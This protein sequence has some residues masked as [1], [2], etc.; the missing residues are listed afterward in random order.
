MSYQ[1]KSPPKINRREFLKLIPPFTI[2]SLVT[3][4]KMLSRASS[5][6]GNELPNII[7][8]IFDALSAKNMSLYGYPRNTTPNI[9]I[10][11][12]KAYV[13]HKH[14]A[15][16][17]FTTPGTSSL[18]SGT[19]PWTHHAI[20]IGGRMNP[21][22]LPYTI[23]NL[24]P[25]NYNKVAFT[26][27]NIANVL[28]TQLSPYI[29]KLYPS[30]TA[31][32]NSTIW[33]SDLF[34]SDYD[35]AT[36]AEGI[37]RANDYPIP[38]LLL[39]SIFE[40]FT[41]RIRIKKINQMHSTMFPMGVPYVIQGAHFLLEDVTRWMLETIV[42]TH[43]PFIAYF[44]LNPPHHPYLPRAEFIGKFNDNL[45][46]PDKPQHFFNLGI[47]NET[48][49]NERR[50]YDEFIAYTDVEFGKFYQQLEATGLLENTIFILT[51]DHGELFERGIIRHTTE[52]LY[53]PLIHIPLVIKLP[54]QKKRV[55]VHSSTSCTD[56]L[57][58]L[59][60]LT[61]T[62]HSSSIPEGQIL[63]GI[64]PHSLNTEPRPV[65]AIEAKRNS[66]FLP[67]QKGTIAM[68]KGDYKIIQYLGY[69]ELTNPVE[70]YNLG[71]D[72]EEL[73]NIYHSAPIVAKNLLGELNET[74]HAKNQ[75]YLKPNN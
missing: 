16:G 17:N 72:P 33:A 58:T 12:E 73:N 51:S 35:L 68:I 69:Q 21:A 56:I 61:R 18:L 30:E 31:A 39:E 55:D 60:Y 63:P 53:E 49:L 20:N 36:R 44:H 62:E 29:N 25:K 40:N 23:F 22:I 27:N 26:Q 50:L 11:A 10:F 4:K 46:F 41:D 54:G 65:F 66:S 6:E 28:L 9:E 24:L 74:L 3:G 42:N 52:V 32:L 67:I 71:E 7:I 57:P 15:G 8:L 5:S 43:Q 75:A 37:M 14:Y 59:L 48:M 38:S 70:I 19:L 1:P 47:D 64:K 45:S 2:A 34:P 13:Y